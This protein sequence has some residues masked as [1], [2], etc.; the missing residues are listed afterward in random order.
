MKSWL[1]RSS[2]AAE[3]TDTHTGRTAP[4]PLVVELVL[5]PVEPPVE[6]VVGELL[7][8]E[9]GVAVVGVTPPGITAVVTP[10]GITAVV[11]PP[12]I[13]VVVSVMVNNVLEPRSRAPT[14][15]TVV[16]TPTASGP[17]QEVDTQLRGAV[18]VGPVDSPRSSTF[19]STPAAGGG[20]L[21]AVERN[22]HSP[23]PAGSHSFGFDR[24]VFVNPQ[25]ER[26]TITW[27]TRE[28]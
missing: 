17:R 5:L 11:T 2:N 12:G 27:E 26:V 21:T 14:S 8:V 7:P 22:R 20:S 28:S 9:S 24:H 16:K 6:S 13:T 15:R 3:N 23:S 18:G 1:K 19:S 4:P 25:P 10:P